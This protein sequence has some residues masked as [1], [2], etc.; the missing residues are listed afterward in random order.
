[1]NTDKREEESLAG[2]L[3]RKV[4]LVTGGGSGLGRATA[5]TLAR[6][7]AKV[8]VADLDEAGSKETCR[9][10][11][12]AGAEAHF[13]KGDVSKAEDVAAMVDAVV[14]RHGRLDCAVN[15]AGIGGG[16]FAATADYDEAAW[17]RVIAVNLTGVWLCL[18][19]ELKQMQ[20][21]GGG[22]I[23][24]MASVAGLVGSRVG[25]AYAASKHG[26]VGLTK[27]AALEYAQANIRVNAVCPSWIETPLTRKATD[28]R[29][30]LLEHILAR[31]PTGKLGTPEDVANAVLWLCS[32]LAAFVTGHALPVDG[33]FTAQ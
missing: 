13:V 23:V 24:N 7:G 11:E 29:P 14:K 4:A 12:V 18:R 31:Q 5:L 26:V 2:L 22:A 15:N 6:A 25:C 32:D 21:Q 8:V 3:Q 16:L 9:G 20:K 33:G 10:I 17:N 1:M 19:S 27:A 28:A 30:E